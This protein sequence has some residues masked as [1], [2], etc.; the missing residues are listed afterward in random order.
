[1]S[2]REDPMST[3]R[4]TTAAEPTVTTVK[5]GLRALA[6]HLRRARPGLVIDDVRD[7]M[8][9][10]AVLDDAALIVELEHQMLIRDALGER[11]VAS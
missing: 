8:D 11:R 9:R 5:L 4:I 1:M 2:K 7:P 6:E 10:D 3:R